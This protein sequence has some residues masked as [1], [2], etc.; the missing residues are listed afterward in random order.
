MISNVKTRLQVLSL[1]AVV[2][3]HGVFVT[4]SSLE[5]RYGGI[6]QSLSV[7]A[8]LAWAVFRTWKNRERWLQSRYWNIIGSSEVA[9]TI[10]AVSILVVTR[11]VPCRLGSALILFLLILAL[12][13][14]DRRDIVKA[15]E[16]GA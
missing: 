8:L 2:L 15:H 16:D 1:G 6:W 3:C 9:V 4:L 7:A 13:L 10:A 14:V 11:V 5:P 12:M